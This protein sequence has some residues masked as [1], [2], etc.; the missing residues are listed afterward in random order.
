ML[1]EGVG[2]LADGLIVIGHDMGVR[3][4]DAADLLPVGRRQERRPDAS[5]TLRGHRDFRPLRRLATW[6]INVLDDLDAPASA[7]PGM[8]LRKKRR[9]ERKDPINIATPGLDLAKSVF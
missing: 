2:R 8:V 5:T 6:S 9:Q 4:D 3:R 7:A 1:L